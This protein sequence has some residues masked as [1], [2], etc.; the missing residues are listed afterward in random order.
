MLIPARIQ[1]NAYR[2][3]RASAASTASELHQAAVRIRR[4]VTLGLENVTSADLPGL[5]ALSRS[6]TALRE[7][8]GRIENPTLRLR[9]RLFWFHEAVQDASPSPTLTAIESEH[10]EALH[11]LFASLAVDLRNTSVWVTALRQW[12][13]RVVSQPDYWARILHIEEQGGF[14]PIAHASELSTL[15]KNAV[16]FAAEPI[17]IA[18]REALAQGDLASVQLA[19]AA[20]GQLHDTGT[21]A[22]ASRRE[23][24]SPLME[25]F[26]DAC[27]TLKTELRPHMVYKTE[28]A[29]QNLPICVDQLTICRNQIEPATKTLLA[30]LPPEDEDA[31][32][33][34]SEAS[35]ELHRIAIDYTWANDFALAEDLCTEAIALA[36]DSVVTLEIEETIRKIHGTAST[37][38][39]DRSIPPAAQ[40]EMRLIREGCAAV[41]ANSRENLIREDGHNIHN[42]NVS[43][44][45][46]AV[47][48]NQIEPA[49]KR[50]L[51]LVPSDHPAVL[52]MREKVASC[53]LEIAMVHTWADFRDRATELLEEAASLSRGTAAEARIEARLAEFRKNAK[54]RLL[55]AGLVPIPK[56][57]KIRRTGPFAHR[58]LGR[59]DYDEENGSFLATVCF[60]IFHVPILPLMRLRLAPDDTASSGYKFFGATPQSRHYKG[61]FVT[62]FL[63]IVIAGGSWVSAIYTNSSS[64][65]APEPAPLPSSDTFAQEAARAIGENW[66]ANRANEIKQAEADAAAARSVLQDFDK[67][68]AA[69]QRE[70]SQI[71]QQIESGSGDAGQNASTLKTRLDQLNAEIR[72]DKRIRI[73]LVQDLQTKQNLAI[74]RHILKVEPQP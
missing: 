1:T 2:V 41:Y 11:A 52:E 49:W 26:R 6:E 22:A 71:K 10:D 21:W 31:R 37:Q 43:N 19:F 65:P 53:L 28:A 57:L 61:R 14:E 69:L 70:R 59:A 42:L 73:R 40:E 33:L 66:A 18:A 30:I 16:A 74:D 44:Q 62:A 9:D 4:T 47:F 64:H 27:H 39:L 3:L 54:Q 48:R 7:A 63:W 68:V 36:Q 13:L 50:F 45:E 25:R 38:R 46:L 24:I 60:A 5:G 58:I 34:R 8:I 29:E 23:L 12:H 55:Y 35:G 72:E 17:E 20:L 51:A 32:V 67:R 15:R 56:D